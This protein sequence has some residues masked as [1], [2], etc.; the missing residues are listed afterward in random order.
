MATLNEI[1][2]LHAANPLLIP[3]GPYISNQADWIR[4]LAH[5][6]LKGIDRA[7]LSDEERVI[8]AEDMKHKFTPLRSVLDPVADLQDMMR[9]SLRARNPLLADAR[10]R[11]NAMLATMKDAQRLDKLPW[12]S[13]PVHGKLI[14]GVTGVRKTHTITRFIDLFPRVVVH[15]E[16]DIPGW[17]KTTQ[18]VSLMVKMTHD[19]FR[20]GFLISILIEVDQLC[21]TDFSD[22]YKREKVEVLAVRV[23]H[24]L[25]AHNVGLLVV[26]DLQ[27]KNFVVCPDRDAMLLLF[28]KLMDVG[29]PVVLMG[30]P[31]AFLDINTFSQD[32]RRLT[33][34][35]PCEFSPFES[36]EEADWGKRLLPALWSHSVMPVD[37]PLTDEIRQILH[38]ASAGFPHY[39]AYVIVNA[40]IYALRRK[41]AQLTVAML[42]EYIAQSGTLSSNRELLE[43]FRNKDVDRLSVFE[44]VPWMELGLRWGTKTL[45][46]LL[47]NGAS[48]SAR[49]FSEKPSKSG[50]LSGKEIKLKSLQQR[51]ASQY[52]AAQTRKK[53]EARKKANLDFESHDIRCDEGLRDVHAQGLNKL[54]EQAAAD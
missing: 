3:L 43:G 5:D 39:L 37:T 21:G 52:Q 29:I 54:R 24:V 9:S 12:F 30:S 50:R 44:D 33:T 45:E 41:C 10:V 19:G 25:V 28:L 49:K 4:L 35:E 6:P 22:Q 20:G 42:Q 48:S 51:L 46:E 34:S 36:L 53:N 8:L 40:Q 7:S 1:G 32:N 17:R 31:L 23:C 11:Q 14:Y 18:I 13:K 27:V 47:E 38:N 15:G 26:D 2:A 16:G